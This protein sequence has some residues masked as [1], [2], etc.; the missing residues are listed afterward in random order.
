VGY[1]DALVEIGDDAIRLKG[2]YFPFGSKRVRFA[3][4]AEV[5]VEKPTLINGK[6]RI[7]GSGNLRTWFPMDWKRPWRDTIFI[8]KLVSRWRRIGFT[9]QDSKRVR[10]NLSERGLIATQSR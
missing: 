4:I 8:I 2:Y 1:S 5:V 3:E 6:W 7:W 9:V 10:R